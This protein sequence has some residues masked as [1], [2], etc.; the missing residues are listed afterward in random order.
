MRQLTTEENMANLGFRPE[1]HGPYVTELRV[2][3]AKKVSEGM[4]RMAHP[5]WSWSFDQMLGN[6]V[7]IPP[8]EERAKALLAF[9]WHV[10]RQ[11]TARREAIDPIVQRYRTVQEMIDKKPGK[12]E[13]KW[14]RI[15]A[16]TRDRLRLGRMKA[17][18]WW[19]KIRGIRN[20]YT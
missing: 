7:D 6:E 16:W 15:P 1:D 2:L 18:V 14:R 13:V 9:W 3:V 4:M 8:A 5:T 12:V 19:D 17:L 10:G 20:P 11:H